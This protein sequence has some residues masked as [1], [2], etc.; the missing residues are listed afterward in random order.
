MPANPADRIHA[1]LDR[2]AGDAPALGLAVSGGGDSVA[3]MRIAREWAGD[4]RLMVATVD[5]GL[6]PGSAAEAA[7]VRDWSRDLHLPHEVLSWQRESQTGNLMAQA[8][9]ARM[10]LLSDWARRHGLAAVLLGHTADDQA[11]TLMMRLARGSGVD[12]LSAMSEAREA[13]GMRWLRPMLRVQRAELRDW[14]RERGIDWIDDPSNDNS[15]FDRVRFRQAIQTLQLDVSALARTATHMQEARDALCHAALSLSKD[16]VI[17]RGRLILSGRSFGKAPQ[18]IRR[19]LL[20]AACRWVTGADYPPR[21]NTVLHALQAIELGNRVTLDGTMID[22]AA[23]RIRIAREP[24]AALRAPDAT[25]GIW[26]NRWN[27]NSLPDGHHIAALGTDSLGQTSW[28]QSGLPRDEAAASPALW[29][30]EQL[31]AAPLLRPHPGLRISPTRD[32]ADFR[33]LVLAH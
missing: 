18:E 4:R 24:A 11:E 5:H 16:A 20:V 30:G 19:R 26:D 28:R 12:G 23:D 6:R 25:A 8:R 17:A 1:A 21:R 29:L 14:L 33:R 22:P 32:A 2:L 31:V 15:D 3:L 27:I 10:R 13:M 9:E 7:R